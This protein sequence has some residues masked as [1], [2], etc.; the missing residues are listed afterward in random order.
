MIRP[1]SAALPEL[2]L[3]SN[4]AAR[5]GAGAGACLRPSGRPGRRAPTLRSGSPQVS[6][7]YPTGRPVLLSAVF[8][9]PRASSSQPPCPGRSLRSRRFAIGIRR[10]QDIPAARTDP[11]PAKRTG[12]GRQQ[13]REGSCDGTGHGRNCRYSHGYC[14]FKIHLEIGVVSSSCGTKSSSIEARTILEKWL[15]LVGHPSARKI[16]RQL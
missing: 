14:A 3:V 4:R 6:Q 1:D 8:F 15:V 10:P 12:K 2:P 16:L 5:A 9:S 7:A 13:H 11:A